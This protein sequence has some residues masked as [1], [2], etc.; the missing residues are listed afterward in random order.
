MS[1]I[2]FPALPA[3]PARE[4]HRGETISMDDRRG[5]TL[6]CLSG[7]VWITQAGDAVDHLVPAGREF[8]VTRPGRVVI[9]ALTE[10]AALADIGIAA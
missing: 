10:N 1:A 3:T 7:Q 6:R 9:Q 4:L 5:Y 2:Q 8:K